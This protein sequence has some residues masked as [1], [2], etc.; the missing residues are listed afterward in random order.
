MGTMARICVL[1]FLAL[2]SAISFSGVVAKDITEVKLGDTDNSHLTSREEM[3]RRKRRSA[4]S[5]KKRRKA[6]K[7]K[8]RRKHLNKKKLRAKTRK[9]EK[10]NQKQKRNRKKSKKNRRNKIEKK[11]SKKR[12]QR[13]QKQ[14]SCSS[15]EVSRACMQNALDCMLFEKNQIT[16][17]LKQAKRLENHETIST[18]KVGKKEGFEEARKHLEWAI[19]GDKNNPKCGPNTTAERLSATGIF[20]EKIDFEKEQGYAVGN[21]TLMENCSA[22]IEAACNPSNLD[23]VNL[24]E[25]S[26]VL[27]TCRSKMIEFNNKSKECRA[28]TE[29]ISNQC[30]CWSELSVIMADIKEFDCKRIK[31]TQK[32]VTSHKADCI[33]VFSKCKRSEDHSVEAVYSCMEDHSMGFINQT[34]GSLADAAVDGSKVEQRLREFTFLSA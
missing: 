31:A 15:N 7:K 5:K 2:V 30:T 26:S 19:G 4:D 16:N 6:G 23:G 17:W 24:S 20:G 8:K 32:L 22:T 14:S 33:K 3:I 25:F 1:L 21:L 12:K 9:A 18:N 27:S 28:L 11:K 10:K 29:S 34:L 13:K